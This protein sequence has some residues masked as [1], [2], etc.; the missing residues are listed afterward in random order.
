MANG[1]GDALFTFIFH[2][3]PPEGIAVRTV[4]MLHDPTRPVCEKAMQYIGQE[5]THD[6]YW[7]LQIELSAAGVG[8][9]D[10][11]P[12]LSIPAASPIAYAILKR[13]SDGSEV[14][15]RTALGGR[16]NLDRSPTTIDEWHA[17]PGFQASAH[18][19]FPIHDPRSLGCS[20]VRSA[21]GEFT[22]ADTCQCEEPDG[23]TTSCEKPPE[24]QFSCC[25]AFDSDRLAFDIVYDSADPCPGVCS[26][27]G[28]AFVRYCGELA[29]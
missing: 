28:L 20:G 1:G 11:N 15:R 23:T 18:L 13:V 21:D 8:E 7:Y 29:E 17:D 12:D 26:A 16:V 9:Y 4:M 24:Q 5:A 3:E 10:V 19:E 22:T 14:A 27:T 2:G 6:D 25:H